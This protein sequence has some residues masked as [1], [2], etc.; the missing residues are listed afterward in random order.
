VGVAGA[1]LLLA[2]PTVAQAGPPGTWTKVTGIGAT[3]R[4]TD[5]IDLERTADGV[6]HLAWTRGR[7]EVLHSAIAADARSVSGPQPIAGGFTGANNSVALA[8]GP[9]GGLRA[10]FAGT[11]GQ[12]FTDIM[13]TATAGPDGTSWSPPAPASNNAAA[14]SSPVY[15]ASGIGGAV[16][17]DGTPVSI[18]GDSAPG[19]AGIHTGLDPAALDARFSSGCCAT[20]P[21]LAVDSATGQLAAAWNL[22]AGGST[23]LRVQTLPGGPVQTAPAS[24]A[25]NLQ[26][27][28]GIAGRIGA[29]GIYVA[30]TSGANPFSG[31]P[32]LW[33]VGAPRATVIQRVRGARDTTIA[34]A[35]G[36]RVWVLWHRDERIFATRSNP[37][38]T[39]F[40]AI[41]S[42]RPPAGTGTIFG[43]AGEA[44][45]GPLDVLAL[46]RRGSDHASHHQRVLP[47]LSLRIAKRGSRRILTVTDA[48]APVRRARVRLRG[49]GA[50]RTGRTNASGRIEFTVRARGRYVVTASKTGY[51]QATG[52]FRIS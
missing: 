17:A 30:Y 18:W 33:R 1:S 38:A 24:A 8:P 28:V 21:N 13:Y 46:V 39:R 47:G 44:S 42:V 14:A 22:L 20:D 11:T 51:V 32:A 29:P 23:S 36:G 19:A 41:V 35:P 5:E 12:P 25:T 15:A 26:Q 52:R 50:T 48:G 16:G 27:R 34:P 31:V 2:L 45:R 10:F 49:G 7:A 37:T 43:L 40:G 4:N 9:A 3:G 6:L